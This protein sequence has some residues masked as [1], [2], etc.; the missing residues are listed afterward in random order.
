M[1]AH[2]LRLK[3]VTLIE[4]SEINMQAY[5]FR[6]LINGTN[7]KVVEKAVTTKGSE[8]SNVPLTQVVA[9]GKRRREKKVKAPAS[10]KGSNEDEP[11]ARKSRLSLRKL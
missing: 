2:L 4:G 5:L 10:E 6:T 9:K 7:N 3:G 1:I 8:S 11:L